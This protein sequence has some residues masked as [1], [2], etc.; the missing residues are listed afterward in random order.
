M[1]DA[2]LRRLVAATIALLIIHEVGTWVYAAF[3]AAAGVMAGLLV[4]A[5][6][7]FST[8]MA[9]AGA[10]G[11]AWF[12]VPTLLFTAL[13]IAARVW[14][15]LVTQRTAWERALDF[16]PFAVGFAAPVALLL[17]AYLALRRRP[18]AR[19]GTDA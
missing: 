5:V 14:A 10:G 4:A 7:F 3:G 16:V 18:D 15:M 12:L 11:T 19:A 1:S 8:R 17:L 6:S 9:S 13:P 2:W